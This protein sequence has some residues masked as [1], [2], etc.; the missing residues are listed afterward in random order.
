MVDHQ[1]FKDWAPKQWLTIE[2]CNGTF[3]QLQIFIQIIEMFH[4][5]ACNGSFKSPTE[6][7]VYE[8]KCIILKAKEIISEKVQKIVEQKWTQH[9]GTSAYTFLD[10]EQIDE[11]IYS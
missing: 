10:L 11:L 3:K 5:N 6:H 8:N 1:I 9:G 4:L 7:H 2:S